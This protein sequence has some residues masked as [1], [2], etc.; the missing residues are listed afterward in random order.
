MR[1]VTRAATCWLALTAVV[2]AGCETLRELLPIDRAPTSWQAHSHAVS[3]FQTWTLVGTAVV[4]ASGHASRVTVRW[5]QAKDSYHLRF[6]A[7]LGVGLFEIEGSEAGVVA[8][9]PDG[10]TVQAESPEALLEQEL[11]WSVPLAGLRHWIVGIPAPDGTPATM[12]LDGQGRLAALE[13]GGWSVTYEEY[14][15]LD[16]LALPTRVRFDGE[17]VEATVVVRRWTAGDASG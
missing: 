8:T 14:G 3:E 2:L 6:T 15:G 11:G 12:Q 17:S 7:R 4:R 13:Q 16:D 5:R 10:R 1:A 9:F